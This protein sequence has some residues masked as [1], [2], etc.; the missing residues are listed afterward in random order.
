M[1]LFY[2]SIF[3]LILLIH[4]N[5]CLILKGVTISNWPFV[6]RYQDR[7]GNIAYD[8]Y[9]IELI[10]KIS[11]SAGF[12]YELYEAPDGKYGVYDPQTGRIDGAIGEVLTKLE[13]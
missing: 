12:D 7:N 9:A 8:G 6:E 1:C 3:L 13:L 2:Y 10:D 4:A 11:K 5:N